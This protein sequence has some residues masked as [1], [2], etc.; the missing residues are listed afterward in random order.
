MRRRALWLLLLASTL[1]AGCSGSAERPDGVSAEGTSGQEGRTV[2]EMRETA[3]G[4]EA[5]VGVASGSTGETAASAAAP[6]VQ[7]PEASGG[8]RHGADTILAVR[9]G[10]HEGYERV[11]VDLGV[12]DEPAGRVPEWGLT[13]APGGGLLRLTFPSA[14]ATGVSD[15]ALGDALLDG[16]YVV[17]APEGGMFVDVL[18]R[19]AFSYRVIELR[20]PAR[21]AVDFKPS[22]EPLESKPPAVGGKTVLVEPRAGDRVRSPLT[23]SGYSR[24]FEAS[25]TIILEGERGKVLAR[26]TV[27]GNDW[28]STWGYFETTLD[29]PETGGRWTLRVG[30]ENARDGEFEGVEVPVHGR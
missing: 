5:T 10:A 3:T 21:L 16:F 25:N 26:R 28:A 11:V 17:R 4:T 13:S 18:A 6:F 8:H 23:V 20:N 15:G 24:A 29:A 2:A 9:Y 14:S 7:E 22:G 30:F 19:K 27:Q 1:V 12:G